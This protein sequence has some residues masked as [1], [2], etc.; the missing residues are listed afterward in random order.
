MIDCCAA[1]C[2]IWVQ[3]AWHCAASRPSRSSQDPIEIQS[4]SKQDPSKIQARSYQ[5]PIDIRFELSPGRQGS[6]YDACALDRQ[7][8]RQIHI[9]D[10]VSVLDTAIKQTENLHNMATGYHSITG[11]VLG[12]ERQHLV[13]LVCHRREEKSRTLHRN[14]SITYRNKMERHGACD[15]ACC[16]W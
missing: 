7:H 8:S 13:N 2:I 15:T 10:T 1:G 12:T 16:F 11:G 3:I 14:R 5:D 6:K 4:R 9:M